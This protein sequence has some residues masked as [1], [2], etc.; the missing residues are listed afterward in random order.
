MND[1]KRGC[2]A[3]KGSIDQST[4]RSSPA[5]TARRPRRRR[6]L[7]RRCRRRL[8]HRRSSCRTPS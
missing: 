4:D 3:A 5:G 6:P 8:P 1:K 7:P 2:A